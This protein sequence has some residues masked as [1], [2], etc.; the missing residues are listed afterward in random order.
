MF[1]MSG[2]GGI[3]TLTPAPV[4]RAS[5]EHNRYCPQAVRWDAIRVQD[6]PNRPTRYQV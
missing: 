1:E 6:G 3:G 4:E 2:E 5:D